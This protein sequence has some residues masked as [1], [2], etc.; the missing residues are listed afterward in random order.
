[1]ITT[2]VTRPR[3]QYITEL[4]SIPLA[5]LTFHGSEVPY[6]YSFEMTPNLKYCLERAKQLF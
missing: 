5:C 4:E 1:M 6:G 2:F 3:L